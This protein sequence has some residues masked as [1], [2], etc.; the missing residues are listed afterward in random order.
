MNTTE[1]LDDITIETNV[2]KAARLTFLGSL[3]LIACC[4]AFAVAAARTGQ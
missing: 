4:L 3:L 2:V 1:S